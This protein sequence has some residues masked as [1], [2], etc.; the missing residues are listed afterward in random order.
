M[1]AILIMST[2]DL[3]YWASTT[4]WSLD[5]TFITGCFGYKRQAPLLIELVLAGATAS[6][7]QPGLLNT[8]GRALFALGEVCT[9]SRTPHA[10]VRAEKC[11]ERL[12][13]LLSR[14]M[15]GLYGQAA[16]PPTSEVV[17]AFR[18][19][20]ASW[21]PRLSTAAAAAEADRSH[22]RVLGQISALAG[23]ALFRWFRTKLIYTMSCRP[24]RLVSCCECIG[25][26]CAAQ[27][28]RRSRWVAPASS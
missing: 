19:V 18:T 25:G 27:N 23:G 20:L 8:A 3:A 13:Q 12:E 21:L 14:D 10:V 1:N 28:Q 17:H 15:S 5:R 6:P 26:A 4:P 24:K 16:N 2:I 22:S 11:T 9:A 7:M